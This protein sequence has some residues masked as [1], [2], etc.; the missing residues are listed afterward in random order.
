M[1]NE[2]TKKK[3]KLKR[4]T[5]EHTNVACMENVNQLS[6]YKHKSLYYLWT[7]FKVNTFRA[8]NSYTYNVFLAVRTT[9]FGE[10]FYKTKTKEKFTNLEINF[11]VF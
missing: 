9:V 11:M 1:T 6:V 2:T 10:K 5:L 4:E 3:K 7:Q 8:V